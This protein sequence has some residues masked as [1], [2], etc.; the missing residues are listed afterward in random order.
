MHTVTIPDHRLAEYVD[1]ETVVLSTSVYQRENKFYRGYA[2]ANIWC[3]ENCQS[4]WFREK[5]TSIYAF[6][7]GSDA[8][9]FK[10]A[11]T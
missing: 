3:G 9:M 5:N 10:L 4:S 7:N 11:W 8:M 2:Y 6:E 1:P